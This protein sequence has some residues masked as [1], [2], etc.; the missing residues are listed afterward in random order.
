MGWVGLAHIDW[1]VAMT[2]SAEPPPKIQPEIIVRQAT[3]LVPPVAYGDLPCHK[4]ALNEAE[5][6]ENSRL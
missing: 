5:F 4:F 6:V 3:G 2:M 1:R